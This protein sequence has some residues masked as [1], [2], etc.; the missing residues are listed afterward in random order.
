MCTTL[1]LHHCVTV[2]QN[3]YNPEVLRINYAE[4]T[5]IIF[6]P[7]I[8]VTVPA[9]SAVELV[10]A[11][12]VVFEPVELVVAFVVVAVLANVARVTGSKNTKKCFNHFFNPSC[13][14]TKF[15]E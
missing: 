15:N 1:S 10:A 5:I 2:L 4:Q 7:A 11:V 12:P 3:E 6:L 13:I 8:V 14:Y 9:S